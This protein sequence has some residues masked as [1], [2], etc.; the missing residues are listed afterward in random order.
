MP[1]RLL[2]LLWDNH[3][4]RRLPYGMAIQET[5]LL[6]NLFPHIS[7]FFQSEEASPAPFL[8]YLLDSSAT[9]H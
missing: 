4:T 5:K 2:L 6:P 3:I 8:A 1:I 9:S 7:A